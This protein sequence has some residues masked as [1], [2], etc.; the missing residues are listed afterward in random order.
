MIED[1][2]QYALYAVLGIGGWLIRIQWQRIED[3]REQLED[4][5]VDLATQSQ[6]NKELYSNV[7]RIDANI[8]KL[9]DKIDILLTEIKC[10]NR[11][12]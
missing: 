4:I 11:S 1:I 7:K 5:R 6:E 9:F 2:L 3:L 12:S 8:D 10:V